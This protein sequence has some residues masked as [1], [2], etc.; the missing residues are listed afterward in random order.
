MSGE[1]DRDRSVERVLRRSVS[2]RLETP[3]ST[4]CLDP[5]T[6]AAW[7]DGALNR[8]ERAAAEAHVADCARCQLTLAALVRTAP[9]A[10]PANSWWRSGMGWLVPLAA[11][12]A[13]VIWIAV[14][15][16]QRTFS[17]QPDAPQ[18][19]APQTAAPP[20]AAATPP[21][22]Q[23]RDELQSRQGQATVAQRQKAEEPTAEREQ[24]ADKTSSS[25]LAKAAPS[26]PAEGFDA[27]RRNAPAP[28]RRTAHAPTGRTW[29]PRRLQHHPPQPGRSG[30]GRR[31]LIP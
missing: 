29:R 4:P 15:D 1:P 28:P 10:E 24:A 19:A 2:N 17:P 5:E 14:P 3:A 20:S 9:P 6:L 21:P 18:A 22:E 25:E 26:P 30:L 7:A 31:R 13:L 16:N 8:D 12:T 27:R 23:K 11:A